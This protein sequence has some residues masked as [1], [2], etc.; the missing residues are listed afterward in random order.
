MSKQC[1]P[2]RGDPPGRPPPG[3]G[4]KYKGKRDKGVEN[5]G[6]ALVEN[7]EAFAKLATA[8]GGT[9]TSSSAR[10]GRGKEERRIKRKIPYR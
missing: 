3:T 4:K 10:K 9:F 5:T 1:K 7:S 2:V 8:N 6:A